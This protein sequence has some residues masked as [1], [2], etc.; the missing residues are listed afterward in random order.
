MFVVIS[1][2]GVNSSE[3]MAE[4][5]NDVKTITTRFISHQSDTQQKTGKVVAI[6]SFAVDG[7]LEELVEQTT[8]PYDREFE[9]K[10]DFWEAP[11]KSGIAYVMD[12]LSLGNA[13]KSFLYGHDWPSAYYKHLKS[14][15]ESRDMP[16]NEV[17]E[18]DNELLPQ[19]IITRRE[20]GPNEFF[21]LGMPD[22]TEYFDYEDEKVVKVLSKSEYKN[23]E[24]DD[25]RN[26][27]LGEVVR[28]NETKEMKEMRESMRRSSGKVKLVATYE[29]DGQLLT[30]IK[31]GKDERRFYYENNLMVR[32]EFL[33]SGE[34]INTRI[35]Y[36]KN[37]L[38]DRTEIFNRYNEPEYTITYEYEF[39]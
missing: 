23:L 20:I 5:L 4:R 38:K 7:T 31:H 17:V 14:K 24:Y 29:Y 9:V 36:Y 10:K 12:G 39:W 3:L 28:K 25:D 6:A 2:E 34:V 1:C 19:E 13:E 37:S 32:S 22:V 8:Y 26:K 21:G 15:V 11:E 18:V 35:H 16:W 33:R 27:A 30:S